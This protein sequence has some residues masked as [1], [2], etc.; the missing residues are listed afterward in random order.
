M[1]AE[2]QNLEAPFFLSILSQPVL[3]QFPVGCR[4]VVPVPQT[5]NNWEQIA[6]NRPF[7]GERGRVPEG[8]KT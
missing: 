8:V 7:Y 6:K 3:I 4:R 2:R 1:G 5:G